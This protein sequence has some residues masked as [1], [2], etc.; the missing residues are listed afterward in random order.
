LD[1]L[2]RGDASADSKPVTRDAGKN[3]SPT[4]KK[5]LSKGFIDV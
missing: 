2:D 3:E 1:T 5:E 4:S